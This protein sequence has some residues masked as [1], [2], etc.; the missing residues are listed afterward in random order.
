[1]ASAVNSLN[2]KKSFQYFGFHKLRYG[3]NRIQS[4]EKNHLETIEMAA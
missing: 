4:F 1:M 3:P 2:F